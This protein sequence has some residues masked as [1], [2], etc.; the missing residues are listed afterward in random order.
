MWAAPRAASRRHRRRLRGPAVRWTRESPDSHRAPD[1]AGPQRLLAVSRKSVGAARTRSR[2]T[3]TLPLPPRRGARE[4]G[5]SA[6]WQADLK[7]RLYVRKADDGRMAGS[8]RR[9]QPHVPSPACVWQPRKSSSRETRRQRHMRLRAS[10]CWQADLKVCLY[11]R[12][13]QADLKV[14]LYVRGGPLRTRGV[15]TVY[16]PVAGVS[17]TASSSPAYCWMIE[18]DPV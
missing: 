4:T 5:A 6:C 3:H 18:S 12:G 13:G 15:R 1:P 10:A 16:S 14:R 2:S 17:S 7:V 8:G 11:V 9:S